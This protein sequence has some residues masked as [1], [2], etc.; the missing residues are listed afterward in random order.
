VPR[1]YD[2]DHHGLPE[3][4]IQMIRATIAGLAP[5]VVAS[6][7]VREYVTN[8]Y[9]PAAA[10][11]HALNST[12][13][14]ARALASWKRRIRDAW[15]T[16]SVEHV[17]SLGG[18]QVE[19]GTKIHVSALVRLGEL[20]PDDIQVQLVTGRVGADDRLYE[21]RVDPFPAGVG[22]DGGLRRYEGWVEAKRAGAIG[23]TV[24]V[25]PYHP[26]LASQ[27][28]MGLAALPASTPTPPSAGYA[29]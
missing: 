12:S 4:W 26:L 6:R 23:Y 9:T 1:F 7:M 28:E 29:R 20:T 8:L 13:G 18:E 10:S 24:R 19:V 5:K 25:V 3:R 22:V 17:E 15:S 16:V 2:V 14:G 21:P 11:S 27:A